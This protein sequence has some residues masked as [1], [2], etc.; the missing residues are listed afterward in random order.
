MLFLRA[1]SSAKYTGKVSKLAKHGNQATKC[2]QFLIQKV[3][4]LDA[5]YI[6]TLLWMSD[7]KILMYKLDKVVMKLWKH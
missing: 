5:M 6:F 3:I 1:I 7:P 2:R 4:D